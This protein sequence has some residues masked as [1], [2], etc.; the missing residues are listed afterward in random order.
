M[1]LNA[2]SG[3]AFGL[4]PLLPL[5]LP[6]PFLLHGARQDRKLIAASPG[7]LGAA[8]YIATVLAS[9]WPQP[10]VSDSILWLHAAASAVPLLLLAPSVVA[11]RSKWL[12]ILHL[13]TLTGV[14]GSWLFGGILIDGTS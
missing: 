5:L 12:S 7:L 4:L 13:I 14:I 3:S 1:S 6:V 8:V 10:P 9:Y 2:I 11:L